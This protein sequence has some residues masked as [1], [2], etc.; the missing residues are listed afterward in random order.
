MSEAASG[1]GGTVAYIQHHLT[2]LCA[3][4]D[5][6]TGGFWSWHLDTIFFSLLLALLIVV[7]SWRLGRN[8]STDTPGGFQN[9]VESILEFVGQQVKDTFPAWNQLIWR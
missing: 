5:C 1:G 8:L 7:V 9:F 4:S 6:G 3:G 2:N